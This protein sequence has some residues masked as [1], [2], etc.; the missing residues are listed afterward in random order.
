MN[1]PQ[2]ISNYYNGFLQPTLTFASL[3]NHTKLSVAPRLK[4][5]VFGRFDGTKDTAVYQGFIEPI[6]SLS[7]G[8][9]IHFLVQAGFSAR[10]QQELIYDYSP[11]I[12]NIGVGYTF[13]PKKTDI[14]EPSASF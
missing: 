5:L 7:T 8:E 9:R 6:L 13:K 1:Y 11:F 12:F 2:N 4:G 3:N 10:L 14:I